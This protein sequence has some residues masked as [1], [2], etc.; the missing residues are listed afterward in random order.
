[1]RQ[2][3][4]FS[5]G[6]HA[7]R[8]ALVLQGGGALGAY[9][10]GLY[11]GLEESGFAPDWIAGTSIGAIN[12][13]IIAGNPPGERLPRLVEFWR[14]VS[15][16]DAFEV[17]RMSDGERQVHSTWSAMRTLVGGVP[18]FFRARFFPPLNTLLP[19]APESASYW[20]V[21]PLRDTL[22]GL[23][24]FDYLNQG[25]TRLSLGAVHVESGRPHY[26]DSLYEPMGPEHILASAALPPGFPPVRVGGELY[27]DG[28]IYSNTPLEVVLDDLPRV[29]TLC[30]MVDLFSRSG[31][32]PHS[33]PEVITRQKH[34]QYATRSERSIEAYRETHNLRRALHSLCK[35]LPSELREGAECS[36]LGALGS[37]TTME[38]VHLEYA[39]FDWELSTLDADFSLTMMKE[40]WAQGYDD[41][42]RALERA[43]W[44]EDGPR[45]TGVVV[46]TIP[47]GSASPA[48]SPRSGKLSPAKGDRRLPLEEP[49][50]R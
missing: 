37:D 17:S 25:N 47:C 5:R 32:A 18:G 10:A 39:G 33:L 36:V 27:W 48:V 29:S 20:D 11:Q 23:I 2:R 42:G 49:P 6:D 26:F 31:P 46:H 14:M 40:R 45:D 30:F 22:P 21:S 1:M 19:V 8:V 4:P 35:M 12:G 13:A 43:P 28:S 9:Q 50:G 16:A 44:L 38:I 15:F 41:A 24:D 3:A 7:K 34:I